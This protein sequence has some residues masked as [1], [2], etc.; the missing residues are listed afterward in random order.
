MNST[1]PN[2]IS[3]IKQATSYWVSDKKMLQKAIAQVTKTWDL[4]WSQS[5]HGFIRYLC[6]VLA[7]LLP[8]HSNGLNKRGWMQIDDMFI[9]GPMIKCILPLAHGAETRKNKQT[10]QMTMFQCAKSNRIL[11]IDFKR[12]FSL[13]HYFRL[14]LCILARAALT[15]TLVDN[16][17]LLYAPFLPTCPQAERCH[18][19][20][21]NFHNS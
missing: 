2:R 6:Y 4:S 18:L 10:N 16:Q 13:C 1:Q 14:N 5:L 17:C 9:R 21:G 12:S 19:M 11:R 20:Y 15:L 3:A 7:R 8:F